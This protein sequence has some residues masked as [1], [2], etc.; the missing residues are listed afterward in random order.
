[1]MAEQAAVKL[2]LSEDK[3]HCETFIWFWCNIIHK[4]LCSYLV[5]HVNF[6]NHNISNFV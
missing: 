1:M 3:F 2:V 4:S 5:E 6:S